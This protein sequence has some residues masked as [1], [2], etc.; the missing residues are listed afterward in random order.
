MERKILHVEKSI[1]I[2][3]KIK[4]FFKGKYGFKRILAIK[5]FNG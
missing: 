5:L 1:I 3:L 4:A 2:R